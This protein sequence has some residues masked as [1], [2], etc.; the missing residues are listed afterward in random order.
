MGTETHTE[1]NVDIEAVRAVI[2][3]YVTGVSASDAEVVASAFRPDA[4]M[5]GYLGD[6]LVVAP[7]TEFLNVVRETPDPGSWKDSYSHRIR[8]IDVTGNAAAGVLE[9]TGYIGADFTN[10]FTLVR[11]NGTWAIASK[12]FFLSGGDVPPAP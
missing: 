7:I 3:L 12:T 4:R 1:T 2:E 10:Y 6:Q 11:E 9:E 5:W 8:S